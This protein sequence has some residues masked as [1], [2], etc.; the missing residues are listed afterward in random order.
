MVICNYCG[1]KEATDK[2]AD[3]N[4]D[5]GLEI[6]WGDKKNW[7]QV[8]DICK[9]L[10]HLQRMND[11]ALMM[12]NEKLISLTNKKIED[13]A[14]KGKKPILNAAIFKKVERAYDSASIEFTGEED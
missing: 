8:C 5:M 2:I 14:K 6:D 3:P 11:F 9:Q 4:L 1:R 10:I 13:L 7:W 12:G